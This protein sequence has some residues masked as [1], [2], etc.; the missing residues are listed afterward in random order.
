MIYTGSA[1]P[2]KD[3]R[4]AYT[5]FRQQINNL[6]G[7]RL[8]PAAEVDAPKGYYAVEGRKNS[9]G[10]RDT[11]R[12]PDGT[13]NRRTTEL[14]DNSFTTQE[15]GLEERLDRAFVNRFKEYWDAEAAAAANLTMDLMR[16]HEAA[17]A[18]ILQNTTTFPLSGNTGHTAGVAW[19]SSSSLPFD[20]VAQAQRGI[21]ARSGLQGNVLQISWRAQFDLSRCDQ[22]LQRLKYTGRPTSRLPADALAEAF[23]VERVEIGNCPYDTADDGQTATLS[24]VWSNSYA[25]LLVVGDGNNP[26]MPSALRTL[27]YNEDGSAG[28][29]PLIEEYP[30]DPARGSVIRGRHEYVVHAQDTALAYLIAV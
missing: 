19:S 4:G 17:V 28:G 16:N 8:A 20:D 9:L 6:I 14:S 13:Y 22:I 27:V 10:V 26:T 1:I 5:Q 21:R 25:S 2:R 3:L 30:D 11:K 29:M 7:L 15:N 24:E 12:N 18:A 23:Q